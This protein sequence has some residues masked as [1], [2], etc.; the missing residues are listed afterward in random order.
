[1][2]A[3]LCGHV[4]WPEL[5]NKWISELINE[6]WLAAVSHK[7]EK[8]SKVEEDSQQ[9]EMIPPIQRKAFSY[10]DSRTHSIEIMKDDCIQKI[11]FRVKDKVLLFIYL[12]TFV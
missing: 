3:D 6:L 4:A 5:M 2:C 9:L 8:R 12:L 10:Y 7:N 11:N 1:M